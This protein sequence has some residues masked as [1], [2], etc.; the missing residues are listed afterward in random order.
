[1]TSEVLERYQIRL[2][3]VPSLEEDASG[4]Y[5]AKLSRD[6]ARSGLGEV[7]ESDYLAS[8]DSDDVESMGGQDEG[9]QDENRSEGGM[10][11]EKTV[12]FNEQG[13]EA[14]SPSD[15]VR[16][17][18]RMQWRTPLCSGSGTLTPWAYRYR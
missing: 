1:M 14:A 2:E 13:H 11:D 4:G 12:S 18:Y 17:S 7:L 16:L 9:G 6:F 8:D 5:V 3:D 10:E 15:L